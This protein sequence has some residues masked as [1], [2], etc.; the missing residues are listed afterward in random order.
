MPAQPRACRHSREARAT[1]GE[2]LRKGLIAQPLH[3]TGFGLRD[4]CVIRIF[5]TLDGFVIRKPTASQDQPGIQ[6]DVEKRR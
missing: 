3:T 4:P 1:T 6:R 5:A 2:Q